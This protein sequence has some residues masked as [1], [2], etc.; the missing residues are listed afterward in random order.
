MNAETRRRYVYFRLYLLIVMAVLSFYLAIRFFETPWSTG[1][2]MF[3]IGVDLMG[4]FICISLY[5]ACM[6]DDKFSLE[7]SA[8]WMIGLIFQIALNFFNNELVWLTYGRSE[9][10]TW[11]LIFNEISFIYDFGLV[12]LFYNYVRR[13]LDFKGKLAKWMNKAVF[14]T[15]VPFI[16]MTLANSFV[17]VTF[18]IDEQ[19]IF[20]M[21]SLYR[22]ADLYTA[23]VLAVS[24]VLF[25]RCDA[26]VKQKM[27]VFS[28]IAIPIV[29][30]I[31]S[32]GAHGYATQYGSMLF[33]VSYIYAVIFNDR[34]K[35]LV[36]TE[37]E[38]DTA[39][40]IQSSMLPN[41]FPPFPDRAE[42]EIY[43]SMDPAREVGGDFYDFFTIDDDHLCLVIADV[44]GKGIPGAMFMMISR[45]ILKST[46]MLGKGPAKTLE[47]ANKAI[48]ANNKEGMFV[49]VW[50][51]ILE[52]S[53]GKLTAANAGHEYPVFMKYGKP[54]ELIKDKH[55]LV[56]GAFE[57][58][59]YTEYELIMEKGDKLFV[60][61]DGVPE[62][63][64]KNNKQ[65]GI[66]ELLK[67]LNVV[68]AADPKQTLQFVK[69]SVEAFVKEADPFDDLT[70]LCL[71]YNGTKQQEPAN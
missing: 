27:A 1:P 45:I 61:T 58:S 49:T 62:A 38:L 10:R 21:T 54:Y 51:G 60:F 64:D 70:M 25:I 35:K 33:A 65:F 18:F 34:N 16:L 12:I 55:G 39:G 43:A 29:H 11:S 20:Q 14:Y 69:T 4:L 42:F 28:F 32:K 15:V 31:I 36:S 63:T 47:I 46:A 3:N 59:A 8:Y 68:T 40:K 23:F 13:T 22:L 53:T 52:I 66:E 48:C 50:L 44:S 2:V 67:A 56:I 26:S 17:P 19:G 6:Y 30:G 57:D 24:A 71:Q 7:E 37:A 5:Y 41:I 9:Y